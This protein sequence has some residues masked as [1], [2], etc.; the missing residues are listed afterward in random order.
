M[1]KSLFIVSIFIASLLKINAQ[2]FQLLDTTGASGGAGSTAQATYNL[3][4]DTSAAY[5]FMLNLKNATSS[6]I[7]IK[8]KKRIISNTSGDIITFCIGVNCYPATTTL[9]A[10]VS[11]PAN[12]LLGNGFLTDFTA[13]NTPNTASVLYTIY[14]TATPSDSI[15]TRI[16]YNVTATTGIKQFAN[17][18][19]VSDVAPNPASSTVSFSYD[20]N[21]INQSASVKIYNMLGSLVKTVP[22]ETYSNNTK[23]DVNSL[24]EGI[25]VYSVVVG[26]KA[27]KTSRL[28]V[29][30]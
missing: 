28:V 27:V 30:R 20:L 29:A 25:Y 15:A 11:V 22:L 21:N 6:A 12:S 14:N 4:V 19:Y 10:A 26:G 17:N 5:D 1:K 3:T 24:E 18:Y 23:I 9:S 2:S 16:N 8:V 7:T 13:V